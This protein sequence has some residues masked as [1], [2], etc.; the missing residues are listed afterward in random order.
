VIKSIDATIF[1]R[2]RSKWLKEGDINNKYFHSCVKARGRV[3]KISTLL[4]E[5]GWV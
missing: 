1:Q 4:T 5:N 2:S 3:N